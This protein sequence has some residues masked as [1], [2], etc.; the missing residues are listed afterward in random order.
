M[1]ITDILTVGEA[2]EKWQI[3]TNT[4]KSRLQQGPKEIELNK[5]YRKGPRVWLITKEGM[6]KLYGEPKN[7]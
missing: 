5:D 6:K 4:I 1:K 2:S 3:S 7:D